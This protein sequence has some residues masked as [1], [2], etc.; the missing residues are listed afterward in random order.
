MSL[1]FSSLDF[2]S[3]I[4]VVVVKKQML[5]ETTA[6]N[7]VLEVSVSF[8]RFEND[9]LSWERWSAFSPNKYLEEVEKCA[10]PGSVAQ[11]KAYFEAHYKRIAARKAELL[12]Q[13]RQAQSDS[14]G[15]DPMSNG[16]SS[17]EEIDECEARSS[18][19][20]VKQEKSGLS[21]E[22][23]GG[24]NGDDRREEEV[25][26]NKCQSSV[27]ER[28]EEID[29]S[30]ISD[31]LRKSKDVIAAKEVEIISIESKPVKSRAPESVKSELGC[32]S[33]IRD[34]VIKEVEVVLIESKSEKVEASEIIKS[35][36]GR[37]SEIKEVVVN[38]VEVVSVES[39]SK[40]IEASEIKE[41]ELE[42]MPK[43]KDVKLKLADKKESQKVKT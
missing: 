19:E 18:G 33:E 36:V 20:E 11:K 5:G 2:V 13:E 32:D 37:D 30:V 21:D 27:V 17:Q 8:G 38:E 24:I 16:G 25:T 29:R 12:E 28:E 43:I 23:G 41:S 9:S 3:F 31:R 1:V 6:S 39:K 10:T 26:S 4:V 35:E 22:I 15:Q 42:C 34:V 14:N 40:K 7:P